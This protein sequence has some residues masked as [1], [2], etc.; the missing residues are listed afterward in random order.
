MGEA[1]RHI[2]MYRWAGE[3]CTS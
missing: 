3:A 2:C 1:L